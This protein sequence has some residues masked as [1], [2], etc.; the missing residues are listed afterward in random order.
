MYML[1][2]DITFKNV[3]QLRQEV[4]L[5]QNKH[6]FDSVNIETNFIKF[7]YDTKIESKVLL[8]EAY[9]RTYF[10]CVSAIHAE[11]GRMMIWHKDTPL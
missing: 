5:A 11:N 10:D 6:I 4:L 7:S 9:I 8:L 3:H 2:N 1:K